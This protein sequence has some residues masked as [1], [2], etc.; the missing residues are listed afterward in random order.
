MEFMA[1]VAR[2]AVAFVFLAAG[3]TKLADL[4]RFR[5]GLAGF[6]VLPRRLIRPAA[7]MLAATEVLV[8]AAWLLGLALVPVGVLLLGLLTAFTLAVVRVLVQGR[9]VTCGCFGDSSRSEI[10][11][12]TV[13][14]NGFL[15]LMVLLVILQPAVP[16]GETL[17]AAALI[18]ALLVTT[19]GLAGAAFRVGRGARLLDGAVTDAK[20]TP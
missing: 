18:A 16:P 4:A 10:T 20:V 1:T 5:V 8:A 12:R 13:A 7:A 19:V 14:R 11:W 15:L 2:F 9:R 3:S 6:E 17:L